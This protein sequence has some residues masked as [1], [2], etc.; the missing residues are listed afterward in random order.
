MVE[1]QYEIVPSDTLLC[2]INRKD[3]VVRSKKGDY[4]TVNHYACYIDS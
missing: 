1:L 3:C 4:V 2:A